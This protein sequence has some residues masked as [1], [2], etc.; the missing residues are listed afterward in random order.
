MGSLGK[1]KECIRLFAK[2]LRAPFIDIWK[3]LN[4][5]VFGGPLSN[6]LQSNPGLVPLANKARELWG[7][8]KGQGG[9]RQRLLDLVDGI[10]PSSIDGNADAIRSSLRKCINDGSLD[11]FVKGLMK[12]IFTARFPNLPKKTIDSISTFFEAFLDNGDLYALGI[13][14]ASALFLTGVGQA[15]NTAYALAAELLSQ[16]FVEE[17]GVGYTVIVGVLTAVLIGLSAFFL[18]GGT[19]AGIAAWLSSTASGII[20]TAAAGAGLSS[21]AIQRINEIIQQIARQVL[22]A[23]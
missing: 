1:T 16:G 4:S 3:S 18:A 17:Y 11:K 13:S 8:W 15:G 6:W 22:P 23:T 5:E 9:F 19:V 14:V 10:N 12:Q 7:K 21:A 2:W 20:S